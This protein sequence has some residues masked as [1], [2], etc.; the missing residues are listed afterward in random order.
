MGCNLLFY[1]FLPSWYNPSGLI[2]KF[3]TFLKFLY[4]PYQ[5]FFMYTFKQQVN[6][7]TLLA[8]N[9][10]SPTRPSAFST[11]L[12]LIESVAES[13]ILRNSFMSMFFLSTISVSDRL[14]ELIDSLSCRLT[15]LS[16]FFIH[17]A[18]PTC[19]GSYTKSILSFYTKMMG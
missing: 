5:K 12:L 13:I 16:R 8:F 2:Q 3:W 15:C 7:R 17:L 1:Q 9:R 4:F 19:N 11:C 18:T 6:K 14:H 10:C